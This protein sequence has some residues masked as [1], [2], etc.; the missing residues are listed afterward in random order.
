MEN[1]LF[2]D[3]FLKIVA[4]DA[5]LSTKEREIFLVRFLRNNLN[6]ND[7]E[8]AEMVYGCDIANS[9]SNYK[10][11]KTG[12]YDKLEKICPQIAAL[13]PGEGKFTMV[14]DWL[15]QQYTT[16]KHSSQIKTEPI[17]NNGLIETDLVD[18]PFL[19]SN[20][21]IDNDKLFFSRTQEIKRIFEILN[22]GSS[23]AIIGESQ[24]GKSS[25]LMEISRQSQTELLQPRQPIYLN[26]QN[27]HDQDQFYQELCDSVGI[28]TCTG[29][30]LKRNLKDH[31]L[32]L[33]LDEV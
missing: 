19:P 28:T 7:L 29:I 8:I 21:V 31:R 33:I 1:W 3:D 15:N 27:I 9:L 10:K 12:I 5:Q 32:L 17:F 30:Y 11:Q 13:N 6:K 4:V 18:N 26:L 16:R 14:L 23:V 2:W 22:S 20:G 25:L 24:I